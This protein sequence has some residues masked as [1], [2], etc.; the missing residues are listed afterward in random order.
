M[1]ARA[2]ESA[3]GLTAKDVDSGCVGSEDVVLLTR[4]FKNVSHFSLRNQCG[5]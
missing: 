2:E 3:A 1:E 4:S 5:R